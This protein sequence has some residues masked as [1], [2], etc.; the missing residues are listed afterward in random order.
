MSPTGY[1]YPA[2]VLFLVKLLTGTLASIIIHQSPQHPIP[3]TNRKMLSQVCDVGV[4]LA[5]IK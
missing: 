1:C 2:I 3:K 4:V 5:A